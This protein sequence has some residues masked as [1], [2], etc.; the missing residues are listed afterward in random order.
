MPKIQSRKRQK[1]AK[2]NVGTDEVVVANIP[3]GVSVKT[4]MSEGL[5][6]MC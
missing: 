4:G 2:I 3:K 6:I 1:V 5:H